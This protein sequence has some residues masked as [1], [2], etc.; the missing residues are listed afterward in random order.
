MK[1]KILSALLAAAMVLTSCLPVFAEGEVQ[2]QPIPETPAIVNEEAEE[3][4]ECGLAKDHEGEC[5]KAAEEFCECG[6]AKGHEGEWQ[7][8]AEEI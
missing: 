8:A 7:K 1:K 2:P 4:C 6:L 5:Q 3:F